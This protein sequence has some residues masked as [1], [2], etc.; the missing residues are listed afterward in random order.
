MPTIKRG[1]TPTLRWQIA[2]DGVPVN[3]TGWECR[4]LVRARGG[5]EL[6]LNE[7]VTGSST[8]VVEYV[9]A[10]DDFEVGYYDAE[11]QTTNGST[12]LTYPDDDFDLITVVEDL[13]P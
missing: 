12:V 11:I 7:L 13:G 10:A 8:G 9:V 3:L 5:T 4:L 2:A 1:D 6:V